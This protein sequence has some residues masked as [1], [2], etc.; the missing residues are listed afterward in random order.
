MAMSSLL[1]ARENIAVKKWESRRASSWK[2]KH[3]NKAYRDPIT[4]MV[5]LF[6]AL[7]H[8]ARSFNFTSAYVKATAAS[9]VTGLQTIECLFLDGSVLTIRLNDLSKSCGVEFWSVEGTL[10]FVNFCSENR[11]HVV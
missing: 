9:L 11:A 3:R 4:K 10:S 6:L 2:N 5:L 1:Q 8:S 7:F